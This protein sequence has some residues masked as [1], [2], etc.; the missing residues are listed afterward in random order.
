VIDEAVNEMYDEHSIDYFIKD[1]SV[2]GVVGDLWPRYTN[3]KR[4]ELPDD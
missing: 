2:G 1:D 3:N 4:G